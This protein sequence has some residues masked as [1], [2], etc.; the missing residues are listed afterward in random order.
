MPSVHLRSTSWSQTN[1]R[2][3]ARSEMKTGRHANQR[4][5]YMFVGRTLVG[6]CRTITRE[7]KSL[8]LTTLGLA[9]AA[10]ATKN[11]VWEPSL[12]GGQRPHPRRGAADRGEYRQLPELVRK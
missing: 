11:A 3:P 7:P 10:D 1:R 4:C 9:S 5:Q 8:F 12:I 6:I 2:R